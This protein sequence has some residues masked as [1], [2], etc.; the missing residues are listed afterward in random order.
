[1]RPD[2]YEFNNKAF[3]LRVVK[4]DG[5]VLQYASERLKNDQ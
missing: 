3:A 2:E 5:R 1:M 4:I